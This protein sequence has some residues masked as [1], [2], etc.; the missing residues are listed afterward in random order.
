MALVCDR[1]VLCCRFAGN[2]CCIRDVA[3][4]FNLSESCFH[5]MKNRVVDYLLTI[6][7]RVIKFPADLE[8]LAS[9]FEEVCT[10]L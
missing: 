2:K 5:G 3:G 10:Y 4:R 8:G 9:D 1:K 6:A 7:P